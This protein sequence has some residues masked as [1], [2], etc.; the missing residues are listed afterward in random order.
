LTVVDWKVLV[1]TTMNAR[2]VETR[3]GLII[4][5]VGVE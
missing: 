3:L 5:K 2:L 1:G 4:V